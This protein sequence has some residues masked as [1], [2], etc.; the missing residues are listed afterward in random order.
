MEVAAICESDEDADRVRI[1]SLAT[2][3]LA[4]LYLPQ[5]AEGSLAVWGNILQFVLNA[6]Y[7]NLAW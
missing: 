6:F 7:I 5:L 4:K 2:M 1:Q 3:N